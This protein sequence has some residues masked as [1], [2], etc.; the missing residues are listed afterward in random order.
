MSD[1]NRCPM[2]GTPCTIGGAGTTH[3]YVPAYTPDDVARL[4]EAAGDIVALIDAGVNSDAFR[5]VEREALS[6]S[7]DSALLRMRQSLAPFKVKS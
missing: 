6:S 3:Y 2:C 1:L 7:G 5:G 4:V